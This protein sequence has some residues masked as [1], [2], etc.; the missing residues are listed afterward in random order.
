MFDL[1]RLNFVFLFC[2][3]VRN[4]FYFCIIIFIL[5]GSPAASHPITFLTKMSQSVR[6]PSPTGSQE[7]EPIDIDDDASHRRIPSSAS[8]TFGATTSTGSKTDRSP[9]KR[10]GKP[11]PIDQAKLAKTS[12]TIEDFTRNPNRDVQK[13]LQLLPCVQVWLKK[14]YTEGLNANIMNHEATITRLRNERDNLL[15]NIKN[16]Q[17]RYDQLANKFTETLAELRETKASY[18]QAQL[19]L[20]GCTCRDSPEPTRDS[21]LPPFT[22]H[23]H[24]STGST[25]YIPSKKINCLTGP[26]DIQK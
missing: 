20:I 5:F 24:Q 19:D 9:A 4:Y 25:Q 21:T 11:L 13:L 8:M 12:V 22:A 15:E 16:E 17:G 7:N 2:L 18:N 1:I 3:T 6:D 10:P 14:K 23:I 26:F